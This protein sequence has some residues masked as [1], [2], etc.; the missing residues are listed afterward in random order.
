MCCYV[1][2]CKSVLKIPFEFP[3]PT[4]FKDFLSSVDVGCTYLKEVL[5]L[6]LLRSKGDHFSLQ[7][8]ISPFK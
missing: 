3:N 7:F 5:S 6:L 2:I 8:L 4:N 1:L